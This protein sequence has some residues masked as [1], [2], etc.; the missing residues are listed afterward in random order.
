MVGLGRAFVHITDLFASTAAVTIPVLMLAGT[1][2]LRNLSDSVAKEAAKWP[3]QF[4]ASNVKTA[5]LV[6]AW[7]Q[8]SGWRRIPLAAKLVRLSI[9]TPMPGGIIYTLA[10]IWL[11][12]VILSAISEAFCFL[13]LSGIHV[14][15][16]GSALVSII[17]ILSLTLLLIAVPAA[18]TL[19]MAPGIGL[20]QYADKA[21]EEYRRV[22]LDTIPHLV[23]L[24]LIS[25]EQAE[26][27]TRDARERPLKTKSAER[28]YNNA[29]P[30]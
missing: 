26:R 6:A 18:R 13:Y 25:V 8:L 20:H 15:P 28:H 24:N 10:V 17:A 12:T 14:P 21:G 1:V 27:F 2:E 30:G 23:A 7:E 4:F 5:K 29:G 16:F 9:F 11:G 22:F 3:A 19:I